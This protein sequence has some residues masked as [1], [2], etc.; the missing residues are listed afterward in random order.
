MIRTARIKWLLWGVAVSATISGV[1]A[2]LAALLGWPGHPGVVALASLLVVPAAALASLSERA[3]AAVDKVLVQTLVAIG[4]L[5]LVGLTYLLVVV[6]LGRVPEDEERSILALSM[7]AAAVAAVLV[8]PARRRLEELAN[9]RVYGGREAPDE[10]L[11]TFGSRMSRAVPM[12]EL[13]LQLVESLRKTMA[14]RAAEIWTGPGGIVERSVSVPTRP[15]TRVVLEAEELAVAA[16]AHVQ[17]NAW[18]AVWAPALLEGREDHVVRVAAV[19]HLGELLGFIVVERPPDGLPFSDDEDRVLTDLAR[20]VGLA[21][22]NVR[23]D[24]ALQA[25][26]DELEQRNEELAASRL[27]IVTAADESRRRI[28]R[29]L[30]DGAQQHLVALAVKVGLAKQLMAADPDTAAGFLDELRE[31]VQAT[32]TE[33]RNLAHGIYPPLLRDRGLPEAL[34]TAA[35]RAALPTAVAADGVGRHPSEVETAVYFCCLEAMQNAGKHA[36][37]GSR[38]TVT[39]T[40]EP[41]LLR[42][43]V[44]DDGAGFDADAVAGGDGFVNMADRLGAVGGTLRVT[45][46][47]GAGATVAGDVPLAP[48]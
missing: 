39:V 44:A 28:E 16:R 20:Q 8:V 45:S 21:L 46:E 18:L 38:L 5:A 30:H 9:E 14:L 15:V 12:D 40:E 4:L 6:G 26:L 10:A 35:N 31:D 32:L 7:G 24:S 43:S 11:R 22:H 2:L 1:V 42:F 36:G 25:S 37:E 41:G 23:L 29:D 34:R 19:A 47:P 48:A 33:L 13:L 3:I 27:R 17:G